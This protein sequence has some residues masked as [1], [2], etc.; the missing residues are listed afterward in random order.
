MT[1]VATVTCRSAVGLLLVGLVTRSQVVDE[2]VEDAFFLD[3]CGEFGHREGQ[4]GVPGSDRGSAAE[5]GAGMLGGDCPVGCGVETPRADGQALEE[6]VRDAKAA[7]VEVP[8][9]AQL[10][11][12]IGQ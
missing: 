12:S 2:R 4:I 6:D 10:G 7:P 8:V 11:T 3:L 5:G 9:V 1:F